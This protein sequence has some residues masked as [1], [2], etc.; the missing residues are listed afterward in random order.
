MSK[1]CFSFVQLQSCNNIGIVKECK[2]Q[3]QCSK[4]WQL[5]VVGMAA[6]DCKQSLKP[7]KINHKT[8]SWTPKENL[9][10]GFCSPFN[11]CYTV[12]LNLTWK[13]IYINVEF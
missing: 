1:M 9:C 13:L 4:A 3:F 7:I 12:F 8:F 6:E 5:C 10:P 11:D 2:T